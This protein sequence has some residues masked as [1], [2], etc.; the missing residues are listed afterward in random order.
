MQ[1][2]LPYRRFLLILLA[3]GVILPVLVTLYGVRHITDPIQKLILASQQVTAGE[4]KHQIEVKTG[5]EIETLADQFNLMSAELDNSY[6]SLEEKVANRT[7]ELAILNSIISVAV[8]SLNIQEI[9]DDALKDTVEQMD[10]DAGVAFQLGTDPNSVLLVAQHGLDPE[11]ASDLVKHYANTKQ[12]LPNYPKDVSTIGT[13]DLQDA[14]IKDA[15][16]QL[17]FQQLVFVP[18]LFKERELGF[19]ILGKH[20]GGKYTA[21]EFSSVKHDWQAN[22]RR[23]GKRA[24]I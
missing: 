18:L 24:F 22:W 9:L 20:E 17:G 5:D 1:P 12:T 10:F 21:E 16:S 11:K 19:F 3:L 14:M 2:S 13:D 4:F 8:H 23:H 6:S 15:L 7:R